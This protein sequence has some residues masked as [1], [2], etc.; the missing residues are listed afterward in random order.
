[1]N[2][3]FANTHINIPEHTLTHIHSYYVM[4][5]NSPIRQGSLRCCC[6]EVLLKVREEVSFSVEEKVEKGG[7]CKSSVVEA[8][9]LPSEE[10]GEGRRRVGEGLKMET[11]AKVK[12][13][14]NTA[15]L[16]PQRVKFD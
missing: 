13:E 2:N 16:L 1:M 3:R 14:E 6:S 7:M 8:S 10:V 15:K 12:G 4:I 9:V 5:N 11:S